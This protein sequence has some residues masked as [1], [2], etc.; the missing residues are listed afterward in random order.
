MYDAS[1]D[2]VG[3]NMRESELDQ[4]LFPTP[5]TKLNSS[6]DLNMSVCLSPHH[7]ALIGVT[8]Q[9][10]PSYCAQCSVRLCHLRVRVRFPRTVLTECSALER[11]YTQPYPHWLI[12]RS[13]TM[14][15]LSPSSLINPVGAH[16][17]VSLRLSF[18]V[19]I[20]VLMTNSNPSLSLS[21]GLLI[22][23]YRSTMTQ[24]NLIVL[25]SLSFRSNQLA[26]QLVFFSS[27][28]WL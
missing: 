19:V 13:L 27:F 12:P 11:T 20:L 15:L 9:V 24:T 17:C 25:F 6:C 2:Q 14:R 4:S 10:T 18:V 23:L 26:R 21:P 5:S 28:V 1:R 3:H 8:Q 22:A 7:L 16:T